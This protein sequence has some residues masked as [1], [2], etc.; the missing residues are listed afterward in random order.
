MTG[1]M[2]LSPGWCRG[3]AVRRESLVRGKM[4]STETEHSEVEG[5]ETGNRN[6][7]FEFWVG[8]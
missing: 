8:L 3:E 4:S 5:T 6:F 7:C 1:P 2:G